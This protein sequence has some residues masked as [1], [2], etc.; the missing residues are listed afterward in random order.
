VKEPSAAHRRQKLLKQL[1][2][3]RI[4]ALLV[5]E[6]HNVRYLTGFTGDDSAL[7]LSGRRTVFLTDGRYT[8]QARQE[9]GRLSIVTRRHGMMQTAA[10]VARNLGVKRLGVEPA[11]LTLA[12]FRELQRHAKRIEIVEAPELAE[13]LRLVKDRRELARI[14]D[15]VRIAQQAFQAV[16]SMVQPG[17]TEKAL[18]AA[19][20]SAMLR[21][22][23]DSAAFPI[24][25]VAGERSALPHGQPS[26]RRLKPGDAVTFDWGARKNG[27]NCD[28]TRVLFV[29]RMSLSQ[30]HL[31]ETILKAQKAALR[32]V[33]AGAVAGRLDAAA[34][35]WLNR[36]RLGK[37]FTHGLG[38][39]VGLQ[40]HEA[41]VIRKGTGARLCA[42]TVFTIE[43]GVYLPR[44]QG[45]RIEDM[46]R[47]PRSGCRVLT[48]LPKG[49][50]DVVVRRA[51]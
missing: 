21:L 24:I 20:E 51:R 42:G 13:K 48:S 32:R 33:R 36:R 19:L 6:P 14:A 49:L 26:T 31:Y 39:G 43:P 34:R 4:D 1:R 38:H 9:I 7:L 25:V 46:V 2:R 12:A 15:A 22:G 50:G 10:R 41:P 27:Y 16:R 37:Y 18:A 30:R 8:T 23:A 47:V 29:H 17:V 11:A 28:L 40:V 3:A 5:T 35:R 44:R 45:M